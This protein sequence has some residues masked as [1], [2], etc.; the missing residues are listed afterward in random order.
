MGNCKYRNKIELLV[1]NELP[2]SEVIE[3]RSHMDSCQ[4]CLELFEFLKKIDSTR[5]KLRVFNPPEYFAERVVN[6]I[7]KTVDTD[8]NVQM[9][10]WL[11]RVVQV[12]PIA[13]LAIIMTVLVVYKAGNF[14]ND[15]SRRVI[16]DF[17]FK[18]EDAATVALAGDFNNWDC[19]TAKLVKSNGTWC[20]KVSLKPGRY[21]YVFV[22]DDATYVADPQAKEVVDDGYGR[23]NSIIDVTKI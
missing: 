2:E 3:V 21:Q 14:S 6:T 19:E 16:V 20:I 8:G 5:D 22:L 4:T 15:T 13:V 17:T 12:V 1:R 23:K 9:S 10:V 18:A 7:K 11:A